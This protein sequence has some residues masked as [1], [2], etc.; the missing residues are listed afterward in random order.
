M[1]LSRVAT[2]AMGRIDST[3]A[4]WWFLA[5]LGNRS[6]R[7]QAHKLVWEAPHMNPA[8]AGA[9]NGVD[10]YND[11]QT[12]GARARYGFGVVSFRGIVCS[13]AS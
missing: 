10:P 6:N 9:N 2:D 3:K 7:L 11:D 1:V 13:L 12:Y 8:P 5:A 4:K